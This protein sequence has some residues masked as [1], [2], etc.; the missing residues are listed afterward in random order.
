LVVRDF[1]LVGV[2]FM[3][4]LPFSEACVKL[5]KSIEVAL[6]YITFFDV[7]GGLR[8]YDPHFGSRA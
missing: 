7:L 8:P 5:G 6:L 4:A 1:T 3:C 2:S